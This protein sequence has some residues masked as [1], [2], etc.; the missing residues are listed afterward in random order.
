MAFKAKLKDKSLIY[1]YSENV[2]G[3][4][5]PIYIGNASLYLLFRCWVTCC[6]CC[7]QASRQT[8]FLLITGR[9]SVMET[10]RQLQRYPS[11]LS[12][13]FKRAGEQ[14]NAHHVITIFPSHSTLS[15]VTEQQEGIQHF[16]DGTHKEYN[17]FS[18]PEAAT[19]RLRR[20]LIT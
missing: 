14:L 13:L 11:S 20:N 3:H 16:L 17:A 4:L 5:I 10:S 12:W 2:Q 18:F 6:Y 9:D 19:T 8:S 15:S 7:R 1:R